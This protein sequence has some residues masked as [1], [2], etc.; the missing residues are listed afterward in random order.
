M[1]QQRPRSNTFEFS[2][3]S[4]ELSFSVDCAHRI[5]RLVTVTDE[6]TD[7][8]ANPKKCVVNDTINILSPLHSGHWKGIELVAIELSEGAHGETVLGDRSHV[9]MQRHTDGRTKIAFS[10]KMVDDQ[11]NT[12]P[13]SGLFEVSPSHNQEVVKHSAS[14]LL[15]DHTRRIAIE[16]PSSG[17]Q[18]DAR[19]AVN[20]MLAA[21]EQTIA[22]VIS[23]QSKGVGVI[24]PP[25]PEGQQLQV[26]IENS[27]L[28]PALPTPLERPLARALQV[29]SI[30]D[31]VERLYADM[32][33]EADT[34]LLEDGSYRLKFTRTQDGRYASINALTADNV[35]IDPETEE[36]TIEGDQTCVQIVQSN[37]GTMHIVVDI[38][39]T[40][41][42][43]YTRMGKD[44]YTFSQQRDYIEHTGTG[45]SFDQ[46]SGS[47]CHNKNIT[48]QETLRAEVQ[49][50]LTWTQDTLEALSSE[51]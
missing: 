22:T 40:D 25:A 39:K 6:L 13:S 1:E 15:Y 30:M 31:S 28:T 23:H 19:H 18:E 44:N 29:K 32:D 12:Y 7:R 21:A 26:P 51:S 45:F 47:H 24:N 11:N 49:Q 9:T 2:E 20:I 3:E 8:G 43:G 27:S 50:Q 5:N 36:L 42:Y 4:S 38:E 37:G 14:G 41:H 33:D 35:E 16:V 17:S 48:N 46:S 10:N 34:Y